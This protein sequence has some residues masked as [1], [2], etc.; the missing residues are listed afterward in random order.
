MIIHS[1][2]HEA[3]DLLRVLEL[4]WGLESELQNS[5][6]WNLVSFSAWKAYLL[7]FDC[8]IKSC[9]INVKTDEFALDKK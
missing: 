6:D 8:P 2:C 7:L 4:A 5:M 1:W 3:R 9:A